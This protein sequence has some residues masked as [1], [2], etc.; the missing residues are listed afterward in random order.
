[1]E[2]G[3]TVGVLVQANYG[4]RRFLRIAGLE[5]GETFQEDMPYFA[6][7]GLISPEIKLR[8]PSWCG[9]PSAEGQSGDVKDGS[10][11]IVVATDAPLLPHQLKRL[12]KRPS[13]G[14]G[15]LGGVAANVSGEIFM[16]FSTANAD[17]GKAQGPQSAP[18]DVKMH[19]NL[20]V[21]SLFE[22]TIDATEEAI[23][24]ALVAA[25]TT[26]GANRLRIPR[27]PH[28]RVQEKLRAHHL[29]R[30]RP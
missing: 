15:R 25:Q 14:I 3:Y 18:Y 23:L 30:T 8:H 2:G 12:A 10:I 26:E 9:T 1:M 16:A 6:D 29:L 13:L 7:P 4:R 27:L 11:I 21:T 20:A 17:V 28:S 22:A 24:N 19:P 5:M